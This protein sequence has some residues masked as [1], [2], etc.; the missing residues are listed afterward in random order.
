MFDALKP[1][2]VMAYFEYLLIRELKSL[3]TGKQERRRLRRVG[4]ITGS[5]LDRYE[6]RREAVFLNIPPAIVHHLRKP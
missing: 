2:G 4:K 1:G 5:F 6:F 3:T